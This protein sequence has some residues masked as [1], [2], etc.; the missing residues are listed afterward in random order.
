MLRRTNSFE[1][2]FILFYLVEIGKL[3]IIIL[4][5]GDAV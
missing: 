3:L 4:R 5:G 2:K 1:V